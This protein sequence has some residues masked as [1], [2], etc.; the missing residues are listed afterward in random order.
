MSAETRRG[1]TRSRSDRGRSGFIGAL[2]GLSSSCPR[3]PTTSFVAE[4]LQGQVSWTRNLWP[5]LRLSSLRSSLTC[6]TNRVMSSAAGEPGQGSPAGAQPRQPSPQQAGTS[7]WRRRPTGPRPMIIYLI[8]SSAPRPH[9]SRSPPS[10]YLAEGSV[11]RRQPNLLLSSST[12]AAT[13]SH[14]PMTSRTR[15]S[16]SSGRGRGRLIFI[17]PSAYRPAVHEYLPPVTASSCWRSCWRGL[18]RRPARGRPPADGA[19][20]TASSRPAG[21]GAGHPRGPAR[22]RSALRPLVRPGDSDRAGPGRLGSS[23]ARRD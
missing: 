17:M 23:R 1:G 10:S 15:S 13:R 18:T 5:S 3:G 16:Q 2:H 7:L 9:P 8:R 4:S 14:S 19:R 12:A 11:R 22:A 20:P 21:L 6:R